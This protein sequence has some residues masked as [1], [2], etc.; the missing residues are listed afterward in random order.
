M[1]YFIL[2]YFCPKTS[3][4]A[5]SVEDHIIKT[6]NILWAAQCGRLGPTAASSR[7]RDAIAAACVAGELHGPLSI[8]LPIHLGLMPIGPWPKNY[9]ESLTQSVCPYG[10][11]D[12]DAGRGQQPAG[13]RSSSNSPRRAPVLLAPSSLRHW[14]AP[15]TSPSR[16]LPSDRFTRATPRLRLR[17]RSPCRGP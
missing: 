3:V 15:L 1:F 14:P 16:P 8:F 12:D 6:K 17:R 5:I 7:R 13:A 4:I 2:F 10:P 11:A 9:F